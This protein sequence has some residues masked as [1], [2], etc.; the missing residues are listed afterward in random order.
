MKLMKK[1]EL[2]AMNVNALIGFVKLINFEF[3]LVTMENNH[4]NNKSQL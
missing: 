1:V 2:R 3:V 4:P